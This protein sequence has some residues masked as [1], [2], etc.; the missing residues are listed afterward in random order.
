MIGFDPEYPLEVTTHSGGVWV[1]DAVGV[2]MF[3]FLPD[4]DFAEDDL[5]AAVMSA[6]EI[7][8]ILND[9]QGLGRQDEDS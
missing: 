4:E 3:E 8:G 5:D 1:V 6:E 9:N 2:T 7:C